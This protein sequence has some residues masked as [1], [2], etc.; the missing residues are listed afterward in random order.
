[1]PDNIWAEKGLTRDLKKHYWE[2]AKEYGR[3]SRQAVNSVIQGSAADVMKIAMV[4]VLDFLKSKGDDWKLLATIHDEILIE[5]PEDFTIDDIEELDRRMT[6]VD[7]F[8]FPVKTD[9]VVF[10]RWGDNEIPV[11][12]Y[13]INRDGK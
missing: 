2:V 7:R 4:Q 10:K 9:T 6:V 5:V 12:E 8:N 13:L 1:M 11:K 3:V